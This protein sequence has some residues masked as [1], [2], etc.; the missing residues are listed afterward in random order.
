I[1]LTLSLLALAAACQSAQPTAGRFAAQARF[2]PSGSGGAPQAGTTEAE[3]FVVESGVLTDP[4]RHDT[5][6]M[7][8][9]REKIGSSGGPIQRALMVSQ[10]QPQPVRHRRGRRRPVVGGQAALEQAL[11][12]RSWRAVWGDGELSPR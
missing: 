3:L 1:A 6:F 7:Q 4:A 9:A 5:I 11:Q 12:R 2:S 8:A 10:Q